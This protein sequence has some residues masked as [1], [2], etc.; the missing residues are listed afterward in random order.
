MGFSSL[1][2]LVIAEG[3]TSIGEGAFSGCTRL[4]YVTIPS[5]VTNIGECAFRYCSGLRSMTVSSSVASVAETAFYGCSSLTIVRISDDGDVDGVKEVL[6][7]SWLDV[8]QIAFVGGSYKIVFDANPG[9]ILVKTCANGKPFGELPVATRNGYAF[10]GWYTAAAGGKRK[11][12]TDNVSAAATLYAHWVNNSYLVRFNACGGEG[13]M[14]DQTFTYDVEQTLAVNAFARRGY[15]FAGWAGNDATNGMEFVDGEVVSNLTAEADGIVDL[16]AVWTANGYMVRFDANGGTGTMADQA[17]VYDVAQKLTTNAFAKTGYTFAGWSVPAPCGEDA[18]GTVLSD[19]EV[20]SN[21][22]AEVDGTVTLYAQWTANE[23]VVDFN[24]G[25]GGSGTMPDQPMT[26]DE[27]DALYSNLFCR[28]GYTFLGWTDD[29]EAIDEVLFCDGVVVSNL[30]D[31]AGGDYDLYAIWAANEYTVRFDGNGGKESMEDQ[32]FVYDVAQALTSNAFVWTGYAFAGWARDAATGV[33]PPLLADA[34]VVSNLT[35]E[36]DGVVTLRAVWELMDVVPGEKVEIDPGLVGWTPSGL[37]SGLKYDKTTGMITGATTKPGEYTVTFKKSGEADETLT[38][39]V[40]EVPKLSV[41]LVGSGTG[42]VSGAGGH[43]ANAKVTLKA[44]ADAKDAAAKVKSAFAGWFADADCT[45]PLDGTLDYRTASFPFVM[46]AEDVSV[47]AKFVTVAEDAA[48]LSVANIVAGETFV[49]NGNWTKKVE[50]DSCSIPSVSAK[51][52][53]A[54]L[55]FDAK[56]LTISGKPTKPGKY[57]IELSLKNTSVKTAKKFS[58]K[59][60]VPNLESDLIADGVDYASDAYTYVAGTKI[61]P[62]LPVLAEGVTVKAAGLPSGLKLVGGKNRVPYSIEGTSTA[63]PGAYTVTLTLA[64]GKVRETAT[65][66]VNIENR[67]LDLVMATCDGSLTNGCKVTGGGL[68]AAGKKVTLKATAA[69]DAVFAGWYRDPDCTKPLEGPVDYRTASYSYVTTDQDETIYAKFAPSADDGTIGISVN[70]NEVVDDSG[71]VRVVVKDAATLPSVVIGS[72]SI[73]KASVKGLPAGLKWDAKKNCFTGAPTKP[74]V[75][76]VTFSLT[77]T[78]VKKAIVRAFTIEVPNFESPAFP[79]LKP[80][81]DAYPVSVGVAALPAVDAGL[82]S[83]YAGYAV[84]VTGLPSGLAWKNGVLTGLAK[85]AGDYTVTFTATQGKDK[86]VSTITIHVEALPDW[87]VGTFVGMVRQVDRDER[88]E[89]IEDEDGLHDWYDILTTVSVTSAGKVSGKLHFESGTDV[90]FKSDSISERTDAGYV[91]RGQ[92]KACGIASD[93]ELLLRKIGIE[94]TG[95]GDLG[96]VD[97]MMRQT[98]R[99]EGSGWIECDETTFSTDENAP[100]RQNVWSSKKLLLP[101]DVKGVKKTVMVEDNIYA[102]TFGKNGSVKVSL[103]KADKPTKAIASGSAT[104][105]IVGYAS[106]VWHT[107][108]CT[109]VVVKK[110][111]YGAVCI[112]DVTISV[113]GTVICVRQN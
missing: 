21:L 53:P 79:G 39:V 10:V 107:V 3:A 73:P 111:D 8:S 62:I 61:V 63:K 13:E 81:S 90:S 96:L 46:P 55:K 36:A 16:Y 5:S 47:Y 52:L 83:A 7:G 9:G 78:T 88:G 59:I 42:K 54:G 41:S 77:N 6:S 76:K 106:E 108:L 15:A 38:I 93:F 34:Q 2:N 51:G 103:A 98:A 65:I 35:A 97:V 104:L 57:D 91:V 20:V 109:S 84:K 85:K 45:R 89:I 72:V 27:E 68:Y 112:F 49:A 40:T 100:L 95:V 33:S 70:G 25:Q 30:T 69:K 11:I 56:T 31:A 43:L 82:A 50:I 24:P 1:T 60:V 44:T 75:Y 64:K 19:G 87:A 66:T 102:L 71:A 37:P 105:S 67:K 58:F 18:S 22:T 4:I 12:E 113:D 110:N 80:E 86:Q 28:V 92:L 94:T 32:T 29:P 26:Y 48:R 23:Y 101:P 99:Q 14:T 17:F 74:G